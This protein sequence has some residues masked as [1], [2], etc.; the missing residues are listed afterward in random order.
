MEKTKPTQAI[1]KSLVRLITVV[2]EI[3]KNL[4][5]LKTTKKGKEKTKIKIR[6]V[7]KMMIYNTTIVATKKQMH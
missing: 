3:I 5:R 7:K 4:L 1:L 6:V 2:V